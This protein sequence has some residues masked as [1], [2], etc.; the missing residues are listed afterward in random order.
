MRQ[1]LIAILILSSYILLGQSSKGIAIPSSPY[2]RVPQ[3]QLVQNLDT[4][5]L[6]GMY[7]SGF[8]TL[9]GSELTLNIDGEYFDSSFNCD[10]KKF[11]KSSNWQR[12]SSRQ[13]ML[14]GEAYE[15]VNYQFFT[16]LVP[17]KT[18]TR[19]IREFLAALREAKNYEDEESSLF[20]GAV[21]TSMKTMYLSKKN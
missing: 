6:T 4:A 21:V 1:L 11:I 16:F 20:P 19:F 15:F 3:L 13:I 8:N 14:E 17:V 10:G 7:S 5:L 9:E 18:R 12:T 2:S